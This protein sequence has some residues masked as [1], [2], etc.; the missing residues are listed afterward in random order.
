MKN[1]FILIIVLSLLVGMASLSEVN[2][3][4]YAS[5]SITTVNYFE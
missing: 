1:Q 3:E 4:R 5:T 2:A